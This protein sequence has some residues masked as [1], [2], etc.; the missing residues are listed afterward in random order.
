MKGQ[1]IKVD[2]HNHPKVP[3]IDFDLKEGQE[4]HLCFNTV[5]SLFPIIHSGTDKTSVCQYLLHVFTQ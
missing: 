4:K 5:C 1:T 2:E 3:L